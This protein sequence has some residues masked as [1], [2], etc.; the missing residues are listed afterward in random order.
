MTRLVDAPLDSHRCFQTGGFLF[1]KKLSHNPSTVSQ[2]TEIQ[3]FWP[4]NT[5]FAPFTFLG[6]MNKKSIVKS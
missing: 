1:L 2:N 4:L 5:Y 3:P 6:F